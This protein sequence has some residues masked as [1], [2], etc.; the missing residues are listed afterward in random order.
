MKYAVIAG[1]ALLVLLNK[2]TLTRLIR[3]RWGERYPYLTGTPHS[4]ETPSGGR[5]WVAGWTDPAFQLL[6]V[7]ELVG[8]FLHGPTDPPPSD[9][10]YTPDA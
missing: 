8:M 2:G 4:Y 1:V 10:I 6:T 5:G 3:S 7:G 9:A